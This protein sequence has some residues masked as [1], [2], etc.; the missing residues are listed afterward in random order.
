MKGE[1]K[2]KDEKEVDE[3]CC[4]GIDDIKLPMVPY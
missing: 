4:D 2:E 1:A 3:G